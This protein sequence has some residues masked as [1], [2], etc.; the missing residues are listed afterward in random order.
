M[1]I[2]FKQVE[3]FSKE[4]VE[5]GIGNFETGFSCSEALV[6]I[7]KLNK[8]DEIIKNLI[9]LVEHYGNCYNHDLNA[10]QEYRLAKKYM[11]KE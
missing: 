4:M 1:N 9:S 6:I 11:E 2:N 10:Y 3:Q 7:E 5:R 8:Q